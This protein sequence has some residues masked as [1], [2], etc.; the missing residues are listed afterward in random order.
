M[1]TILNVLITVLKDHQGLRYLSCGLCKGLLSLWYSKEQRTDSTLYEKFAIMFKRKLQLLQKVPGHSSFPVIQQ[2][3]A[4]ISLCAFYAS[5]VQPE[6]AACCCCFS[7]RLHQV[8]R[9]AGSN[10][11]KKLAEARLAAHEAAAILTRFQDVSRYFRRFEKIHSCSFDTVGQTCFREEANALVY[12]TEEAVVESESKWTG[13]FPITLQ[14]SETGS[15]HI[16]QLQPRGL[17]A[18]ALDTWQCCEKPCGEL[19]E[20]KC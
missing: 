6:D 17:H 18:G 13:L 9:P 16:P 15:H 1:I 10:R 2:L 19:F 7:C 4:G 8:A 5:K 20:S 12:K 14:S 11:A 3:S